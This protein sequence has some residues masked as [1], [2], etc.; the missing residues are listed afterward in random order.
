MW[1]LIQ[2]FAKRC[3]LPLPTVFFL[4]KPF[5]GMCGVG[6]W[7][8]TG[9]K[10][11][12]DYISRGLWFLCLP[13]SANLFWVIK[14]DY[15]NHET[16][17]PKG[18]FHPIRPKGAYFLSCKTWEIRV[19]I[20]EM[21]MFLGSAHFFFFFQLNLS[22]MVSVHLVDTCCFLTTFQKVSGAKLVAWQH[23]LAQ[24][25]WRMGQWLTIMYNQ[26]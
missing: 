24:A 13:V 25:G 17:L 16:E 2:T 7:Y 26:V 18:Q 19:Y 9:T 11:N 4:L 6:K 23:V 12:C 8:V 21:D 3:R 22:L 5:S 14:L 10:H 20:H 15:M 1:L